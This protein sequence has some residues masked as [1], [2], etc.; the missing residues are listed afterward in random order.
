[1]LLPALGPGPLGARSCGELVDELTD[2]LGV[3][4]EGP[5]PPGG[6]GRWPGGPGGAGAGDAGRLVRAGGAAGVLAVG[7][8]ALLL[9]GT[10]QAPV[11]LSTSPH[12]VRPGETVIIT[13]DHLP[14]GQSGTIQLGADVRLGSFHADGQG[15]ARAAVPVPVSTDEGEQVVTLCWSGRCAAAARL[16]VLPPRG[17]GDVTV[18][19]APRTERPPTPR[20]RERPHRPRPS[21]APTFDG[22]VPTASPPPAPGRPASGSR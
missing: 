2:A 1:V 16:A 15:V 20:S 11:E 4:P 12:S 3:R 9:A 5:P 8:G 6:S 21:P 17:D 14:S 10:R 7:L 19:S 22:T 18:A 13:V